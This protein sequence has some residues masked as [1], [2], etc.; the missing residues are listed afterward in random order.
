MVLRIMLCIILMKSD[1]RIRIQVLTW[2]I[3]LTTIGSLS[4]IRFS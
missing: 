3:W 2:Q 4:E 1:N